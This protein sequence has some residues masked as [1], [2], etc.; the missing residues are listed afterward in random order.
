MIANSAGNKDAAVRYFEAVRRNAPRGVKGELVRELSD[1]NIARVSYETK[2]YPESLAYY[3]QIPRDS[4]NWLESLFESSWA[5]FMM[6]KHNNVLGEIHTLQSPF[7]I[8]R[9]YPESYILQAITFLKLCRI[10]ETKKSLVD[11]SKRYKPVMSSL[12]GLLERTRNNPKELYKLVQSYRAGSLN[13]YREVWPILDSLSRTDYY[14]ESKDAVRF[15]N[16]EINR[17][18]RKAK[19]RS[20]GLQKSLLSFLRKKKSLAAKASG[21]RLYGSARDAFEY[22]KELNNQ[23]IRINTELLLKNLDRLR[24]EL[25]IP[26]D[27]KKGDFIGGRKK[28]KVGQSLE[29]WPFE[30]E[31]WEDELGYYVYNLESKCRRQGQRSTKSRRRK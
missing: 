17:L 11:F 27:V 28:L 8:D 9:F 18:K 5:Y 26:V 24:Q 13:K 23:T 2:D 20:S 1:L 25:N 12:R 30:G 7:F 4:D 22:L 3:S 21:V 14:K 19:W 16:R 10:K 29:Y 15:S 31:Y 6:A